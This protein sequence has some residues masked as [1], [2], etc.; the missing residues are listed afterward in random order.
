MKHTMH[1]QKCYLLMKC[2]KET[3]KQKF[4]NPQPNLLWIWATAA[5]SLT[6]I[7]ERIPKGYLHNVCTIQGHILI[8]GFV[9]GCSISSALA[10][11]I[12]HSCTNNQYKLINL[13]QQILSESIYLK[14]SN[15]SRTL[16]GNKIVA[17]S[18]VVGASPVGAA[19]IT[20]SLST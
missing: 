15:I 2:K 13:I 10:L 8:D 4:S 17:H 19:P 20:S 1:W 12:P 9:Q 11:E 3:N 14:V 7:W 6:K 16:A 5:S 18:D